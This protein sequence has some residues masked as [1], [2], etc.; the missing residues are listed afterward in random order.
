MIIIIIFLCNHY[1]IYKIC[2]KIKKNWSSGHKNN[3]QNGMPVIFLV[4]TLSFPHNIVFIVQQKF[5]FF[6]ITVIGSDRWE[7]CFFRGK[8]CFVFFRCHTDAEN[9]FGRGI[10]L[11]ITKSCVFHHF[12]G[13]HNSFRIILWG[14]VSFSV[15]CSSLIIWIKIL[16]FFRILTENRRYASGNIRDFTIPIDIFLNRRVVRL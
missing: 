16:I 7:I 6:V 8:R 3:R 13:N 11:Q 9:V 10:S 4:V 15:S 5:A 2:L 12:N 1:K 14:H